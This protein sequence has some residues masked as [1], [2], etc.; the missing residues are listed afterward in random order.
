MAYREVTMIEVREV[1]RRWLAGAA[2]KEIAGFL[3]LDP[4][5]VR[6]YV[7]AAE[8][9]GLTPGDGNALTEETFTSVL[10]ALEPRRAC[11]AGETWKRCEAARERIEAWLRSRVRLSKIHRLL[12]R[13]GVD[14]PYSSL[15]RYATR[16]LGFGRKAPSVPVADAPPGKEVQL[17]TGWMDHVLPDAAGR[18][19]RMRAWIFTPVLSRY[20]FVWPCFGE[21]TQSAIEACEAAWA[22]YGGVFETVI[23]DNTK[24]IVHHADPVAA[25][26]NVTFLEYAQARGFAVDTA[27]VRKPRDKARV[28][29]TVR[30]VRDD[31]FAGEILRSLEDAA[32]RGRTWCAVEYGMRRHS[33]TQRMPREHFES[34]EKTLLRSPPSEPY[35]T[36]LWSEPRVAPDQHAQVAKALYS[37]PR[38]YRGCVLRARA[39]R[40]QVR[41]Y[42][43]TTL[44]KVH[45]RQP[46]HGRATDPQ[47][48]PKD[49]FACGQRDARYLLEQAQ[50]RGE[51]V[52]R[53][54]KALLDV[55]L[56]WTRMR[57]VYKLFALSKR[58]G[59]ERLDAAC[60]KA[61]AAELVDV[62]RL[63]RM[64]E[65][66]ASLDV[67][68]P[69]VTPSR[70]A[71][72]RFLRDKDHFAIP[73]K[74]EDIQ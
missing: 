10:A 72:S 65:Q 43:G 14:V 44:V 4:K 32:L 42:K 74:P 29:R 46:A 36:P 64:L 38:E 55:P 70:A 18:R 22:F 6:R 53:F 52:G 41:F 54:A 58:Y 50:T 25:Q 45:A 33:T 61:L 34:T 62:S 31:C 60:A 15:H 56:P 26:L 5:T 39:D 2:K 27:R 51:N 1:L 37:L 30:D 35:D 40:C 48:F 59:N 21:T 57:R 66:A 47:D 71:P 17:D 12:K 69:C 49:A 9:C 67:P 68:C 28:E 23:V 7:R 8:S 73:T 11:S 63:A 16:V 13:E 20:R 19:R 3:G 24:A